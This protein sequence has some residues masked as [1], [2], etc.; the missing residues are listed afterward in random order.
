MG[1]CL[2]DDLLLLD[3]EEFL[4]EQLLLQQTGVFSGVEVVDVVTED[5]FVSWEGR[6]NNQCDGDD[7]ESLQG[8]I[9]RALFSNFHFAQ[10]G[11]L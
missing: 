4:E 7:Q 10:L 8:W 5:G 6:D 3:E 1:R 2:T 9:E 11:E